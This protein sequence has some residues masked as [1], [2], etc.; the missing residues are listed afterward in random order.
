MHCIF[1]YRVF[2]TKYYVV[3]W[4]GAAHAEAK[5][6][7]AEVTENDFHTDILH[8]RWYQPTRM[9]R[10][11]YLRTKQWHKMSYELELLPVA[12]RGRQNA[13]ARHRMAEQHQEIP[14]TDVR[15]HVFSWKYSFHVY[16]LL[17]F[18]S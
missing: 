11:K 10:E 7:I 5:F 18:C 12:Q 4:G 15:I 16:K 6:L 2:L 3:V 8:V 9:S 17:Q 13:A 1:L 14:Y